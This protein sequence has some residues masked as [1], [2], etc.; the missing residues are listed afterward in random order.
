[1]KSKKDAPV[2]VVYSPRILRNLIEICAEMG[3]GRETILDWISRGAP[4]V[5]EFEGKKPRYS[6]EAA[7][8][9]AWR[10]QNENKRYNGE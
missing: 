4:I 10:K 8:L 2:S 6:C 1:M 3:V 7:A 9:Q 5:C